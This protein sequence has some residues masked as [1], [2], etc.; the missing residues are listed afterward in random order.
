MNYYEL[1]IGET[2]HYQSLNDIDFYIENKDLNT[3]VIYGIYNKNN[4]NI[5]VKKNIEKNIINEYKISFNIDAI[6]VL[7]IKLSNQIY[8]EIDL[9]IKDSILTNINLLKMLKNKGEN[10]PIPYDLIKLNTLDN[11]EFP[12]AQKYPDGTLRSGL[13]WEFNLPEL[14]KQFYVHTSKL[15][16]IFKTSLIQEFISIT[17]KYIIFKTVNSTYKI[18]FK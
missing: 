7:L 16:I 11:A 8:T 12:Q 15:N 1:A 5:K 18:E 4:K 2:M 6:N 9:Y 14:N 13:L 10:Y 3:Y 17:D